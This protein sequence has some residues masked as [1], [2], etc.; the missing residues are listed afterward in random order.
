[1]LT[2]LALSLPSAPADYHRFHSPIGPSTLSEIHS[3]QGSYL[4]VNPCAVNQDF[5]VFTSNRRDTI[6]CEWSPTEG[7]SK[8]IPVAFVAVG[9]ML[10]GGIHW[11]SSPGAS[12]HRGQELGYFAYGG[13]TCIAV[14][15]PEANVKW[16][17]DLK[18]N[19]LRQR[20]TIVRV[21]ERIGSI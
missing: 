4:T 11:T 19:S 6:L 16:D 2:S 1:M 3:T 7:I 9:A 5:D 18:K 17:E 15:P 13:S 14:F 12:P 10:V 8:K 20:E 21:G